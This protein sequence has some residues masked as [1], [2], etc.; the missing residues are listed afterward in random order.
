MHG[1]APSPSRRRFWP[2]AI[3][4]PW[5]FAFMRPRQRSRRKPCHSMVS[6]MRVSTENSRSRIACLFGCCLPER[7]RLIVRLAFYR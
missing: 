3:S 2:A 5:M 1:A 4:N 6:A 7:E